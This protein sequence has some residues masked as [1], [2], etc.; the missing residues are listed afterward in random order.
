MLSFAEVQSDDPTAHEAASSGRSRARLSVALLVAAGL[1]LIGAG[2]LV[3]WSQGAAVFVGNP[4]LAALA[5]CF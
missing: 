3:W 2:A 4:V 1:S 5:W